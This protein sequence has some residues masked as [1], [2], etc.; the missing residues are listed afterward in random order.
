MRLFVHPD[1][2]VPVVRLVTQDIRFPVH[3][4]VWTQFKK[5]ECTNKEN[6]LNLYYDSGVFM[7]KRQVET[8][9]H[10]KQPVSRQRSTPR[11]KQNRGVRVFPSK[12]PSHTNR[13]QNAHLG[14]TK[15]IPLYKF[16]LVQ[17]NLQSGWSSIRQFFSHV[18][19]RLYIQ[20]E[21]DLPKTITIPGPDFAT[22]QHSERAERSTN[23]MISPKL[24]S[25]WHY[26]VMHTTNRGESLA[27][28]QL[29]SGARW[30]VLLYAK[31]FEGNVSFEQYFK[32][33]LF[34]FYPQYFDDVPHIALLDD[35]FHTNLFVSVCIILVIV[36]LVWWSEVF[37]KDAQAILRLGKCWFLP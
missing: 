8:S 37:L 19:D 6:S 16:I 2:P 31:K 5:S 32:R 35:R 30:F 11:Q 3:K 28:D 24:L 17:K 10:L 15:N 1:V 22:A 4:T 29:L 27:L 12:H 25:F 14:T 36:Q 18:M 13:S 9:N 23:H 34:A 20:E 26:L 7:Y 21:T 33:V